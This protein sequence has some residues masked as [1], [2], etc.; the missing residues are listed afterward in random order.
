MSCN[1]SPTWRGDIKRGIDSGFSLCCIACFLI[2]GEFVLRGWYNP[3]GAK[4][5]DYAHIV[6][7]MCRIWHKLCRTEIFYSYCRA[8]NWEQFRRIRCNLCLKMP[9]NPLERPRYGIVKYIDDA[10][11]ERRTFRLIE[12]KR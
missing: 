11:K 8:C 2:R 9:Y 3:S 7:P 5:G 10:G 4:D 12:V 1:E 6:C